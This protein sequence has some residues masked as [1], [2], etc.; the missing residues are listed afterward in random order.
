MTQ[1]FQG[2]SIE[3]IAACVPKKKI[4][5]SHFSQLLDPKNL[6]K[7]EKNTRKIERFIVT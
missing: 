6:R 3:A 4:S 7:F 5:G 2:I 1:E